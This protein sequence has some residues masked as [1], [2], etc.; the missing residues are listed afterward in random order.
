MKIKFDPST[1]K[2]FNTFGD[3][4]V[5]VTTFLGQFKKPFDTEKM[6]AKVAQREGVSQDAIKKFWQDL[7][8]IATDKGHAAHE[9]MEEFIKTGNVNIAYTDLIQSYKNVIKDCR[10]NTVLS[11]QILACHDSLIAGTSDLILEG[12]KHFYVLDFKTNKKFNYTNS[13]GD[14]F[15]EP[16]EYLPH[17]EFTSYS[18]Q[19][20][21]YA[22]L[23]EKESKKKCAG[24]RVLFLNNKE[25]SRYWQ[26]IHIIYMKD[27]IQKL[28][29][30]R[31]QQYAKS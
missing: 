13:Y 5:S 23:K 22:Y 1:H 6:S 8:K 16:I 18:L 9:A 21:M 17:C 29:N 10:Y 28:V 15:L 3:E 2:Y 30:T 14:Y 12:D 25:S 26:Q 19:L 31:I 20:S 7:T 11:E 4:Y 24:I 27:T